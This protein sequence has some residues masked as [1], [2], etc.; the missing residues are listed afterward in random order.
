MLLLLLRWL[1]LLLLIP[2]R[3]RRALM[4]LVRLRVNVLGAGWRATVLR[5]SEL[6]EASNNVGVV[7]VKLNCMLVSVERII[8]LV[9]AG[10]V[11]GAQIVPHLGNI[12]VDSNGSKVRVERVSKLIDLVIQNT[13]R[14]PKGR[15]VAVAIYSL[16]IC[17][18]RIVIFLLSHVTAAKKIPRLGVSGIGLERLGEVVDGNVLV[19][20]GGVGLVIKPAKLLQHL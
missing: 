3:L 11:K 7:G 14:A 2:N 6:L 4:L 12:G 20:K 10:L 13:N 17:F 15:V 18:I 19:G 5:A 8:D 1:L 9:I 16:L